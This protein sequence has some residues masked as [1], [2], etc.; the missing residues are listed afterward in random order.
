MEDNF[1]ERA[2][3]EMLAE[4][5]GKIAIAE[6]VKATLENV[7]TILSDDESADAIERADHISKG[8]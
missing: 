4:T 7:L 3:R 6:A 8:S 5:R 2:T 1:V